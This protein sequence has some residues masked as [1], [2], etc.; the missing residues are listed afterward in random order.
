MLVPGN[1]QNSGSKWFLWFSSHSSFPCKQFG[2]DVNHHEM[3]WW[4]KGSGLCRGHAKLTPGVARTWGYLCMAACHQ[5]RRAHS[6]VAPLGRALQRSQLR[7]PFLG[8]AVVSRTGTHPPHLFLLLFSP[9]LT[10]DLSVLSRS[11]P[12]GTWPLSSSVGWALLWRADG[13]KALLGKQ[14]GKSGVDL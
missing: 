9:C 8:H 4:D 1:S 14:G 6:H 13:L 11:K 3:L 7:H 12:L 5:G 10:E 2:L